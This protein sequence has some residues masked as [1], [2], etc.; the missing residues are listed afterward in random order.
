MNHITNSQQSFNEQ[1]ADLLHNWISCKSK[2]ER[3]RI[4]N[5]TQYEIQEE[6]TNS[7]EYKWFVETSIHRKMHDMMRSKSERSITF[8]LFIRLRRSIQTLV[9]ERYDLRSNRRAF[10][11]TLTIIKQ[12]QSPFNAAR[13]ANIEHDIQLLDLG[14]SKYD[15]KI[16]DAA[17]MLM[18]IAPYIDMLTTFEERCDLLNINVA[19][20]YKLDGV[21]DTG[22]MHMI[23]VYGLEDSAY[24]RGSDWKNGAMANAINEVM[25]DF[26]CNTPEGEKLCNSMFEPGGLFESIPM[27]KMQPDG[28]LNKMPPR[29][30]LVRKQ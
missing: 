6:F 23:A 26:L 9:A 16:K 2:D 15:I 7:P 25:V 22:I 24:H 5:M 11:R 28:V 19:D 3:A 21:E 12:Q 18:G 29:L 27:Y 1:V 14:C 13:I 8:N 4:F 20:R 17:K 30:R 10:R